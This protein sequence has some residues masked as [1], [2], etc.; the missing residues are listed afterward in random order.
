LNYKRK[1]LPNLSLL[2][3]L[4]FAVSGSN[5]SV[6]WAISFLTM[7]LSDKRLRMSHAVLEIRLIIKHNDAIWKGNEREEILKCALEIYLGEKDEKW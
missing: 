5:S 3:E 6:E 1:E 7:S 4:V 2:A